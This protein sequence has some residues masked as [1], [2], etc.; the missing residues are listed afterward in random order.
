M[1]LQYVFQNC[2]HRG[3][4]NFYTLGSQKGFLPLNINFKDFWQNS[5]SQTWVDLEQDLL[6]IVYGFGTE[7]YLIVRFIDPAEHLVKILGLFCRYLA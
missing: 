6:T 4:H 2:P 5:P 3:K 1:S 7:H